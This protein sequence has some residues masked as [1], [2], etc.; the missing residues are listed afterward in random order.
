MIFLVRHGEATAG[1]GD[2]PDPGLSDLG[3]RQ[4]EAAAQALL[5]FGAKAAV[6]SPMMRCRETASAFERAAG[7]AATVEPVVSEIVTPEGVDDRVAWLRG[8]MEGTWEAEG[9][10]FEIWRRDILMALAALPENTAVFS[11]FVAINAAV[12]L[13]DQDARTIVF[14]PGHCSIT[15]IDFSGT[16]PRVA[17]YGS[18][19]ATRVL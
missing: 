3:H 10:A 12:S 18:Q 4:A 15:Q 14:R 9:A 11:H 7:C 1:W 19:A 5:G 13:I 6:C 8:Y 17:E 16:V 2:H